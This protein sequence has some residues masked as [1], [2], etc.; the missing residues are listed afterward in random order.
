ML[1]RLRSHVRHNVV[2]Y[3]ALFFALSGTA[4]GANAAL[5][6]GDSAGGDLSGTYPNP[7]IAPNAVN[8]GK[9]SDNSLTGDDISEA[10]LSGVSP[11]GAAGGDLTGT[12]P[13]PSITANA[14]NSGK[15]SN[16]S[17]TGDDIGNVT[18][19][20]NL[21][22]GSFFHV[23]AAGG[24][25]SQMD[26][27]SLDDAAPDFRLLGS[28]SLF[29]A[30]EFDNDVFNPDSGWVVS[31]FTVPMDA[32]SGGSGSF[33]LRVSK[34]SHGG[35]TDHITGLVSD[36]GGGSASGVVEITTEAISTYTMTTSGITYN[37]G[38]S[39]GVAFEPSSDNGVRIHSIE[40][41]YTAT[42]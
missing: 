30:I 25:G 11:S 2:G 37:P 31:T 32:I 17:L 14:V 6:I 39:L 9:V 26:F 28:P 42:Q 16:E 21:P 22:L 41:R 8:S 20:V 29:P 33:A 27:S 23:V 18:R 13:N 1:S 19:S 10:T 5:K 36:F 12:Y 34:L 24:S 15:V 38:S 7:S 3:L 4:L 35:A 40:F